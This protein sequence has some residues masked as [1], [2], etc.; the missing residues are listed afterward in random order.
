[1]EAA[2]PKEPKT[3][4]F[5]IAQFSAFQAKALSSETSSAE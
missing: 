5:P 3:C 4:I 2:A 1:M